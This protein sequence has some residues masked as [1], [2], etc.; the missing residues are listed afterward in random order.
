MSK[1]TAFATAVAT[2]VNCWKNCGK[3]YHPSKWWRQIQWSPR[4]AWTKPTFL[5]DFPPF[6]TKYEHVVKVFIKLYFILIDNFF[7]RGSYFI[8]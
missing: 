7:F 3:A 1:A 6:T 8:I 5:H 4:T 2:A